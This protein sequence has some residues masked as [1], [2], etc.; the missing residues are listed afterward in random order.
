L[1]FA[2]SAYVDYFGVGK[3]G[4]LPRNTSLDLESVIT[5]SIGRIL[6]AFDDVVQVGLVRLRL[7]E[8]SQIATY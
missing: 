6:T 5:K 8:I 4:P 2:W 7:G 3:M 1:H